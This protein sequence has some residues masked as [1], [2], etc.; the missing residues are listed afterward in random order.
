MKEY[1]WN[2]TWAIIIAGFGYLLVSHFFPELNHS[3]IQKL[4]SFYSNVS[5]N[6]LEKYNPLNEYNISLEDLDYAVCR[7]IVDNMK[8]VFINELSEN[9]K[10]KAILHICSQLIYNK[11]KYT[12]ERDKDIQYMLEKAK[13][14][15]ELIHLCLFRYIKEHKEYLLNLE[16][17]PFVLCILE[18]AEQQTLQE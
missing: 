11:I 7:Y 5:L 12:I 13:N 9:A 3:I 4:D 17:E 14:K 15:E 1:F 8:P 16:V 10:P 6:E 2:L 18:N